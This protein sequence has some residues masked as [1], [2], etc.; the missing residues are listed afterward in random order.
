MEQLLEYNG[1][2]YYINMKDGGKLY[3]YSP[4]SQMDIRITNLSVADFA[5]YDGVLY[6]ST[7][8]LVV[9]NVNTNAMKLYEK[10]GFYSAATVMYL[11]F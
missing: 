11:D 7:V 5:I 1:D 10:L 3:R 8:R 9:K 2:I 4:S 6:Y